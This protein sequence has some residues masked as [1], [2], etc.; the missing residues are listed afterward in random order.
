MSHQ[1]ELQSSI[2]MPNVELQLAFVILLVLQIYKTQLQLQLP[3]I[4]T[5]F[6]H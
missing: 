1:E 6:Q 4:I 3:I 2:F 5:L